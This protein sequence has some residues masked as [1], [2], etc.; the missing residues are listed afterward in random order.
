MTERGRNIAAFVATLELCKT[1]P[2]FETWLLRHLHLPKPMMGLNIEKVIF[3]LN[4]ELDI[5]VILVEQNV[6]FVREVSLRFAMMEKGRIVAEDETS[7]LTVDLV[8][9]HMTV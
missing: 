5:T 1:P 2:W 3:K 9:K 4:R 7:K 6:R 8:R